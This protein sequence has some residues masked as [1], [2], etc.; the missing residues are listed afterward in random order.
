[1]A[2]SAMTRSSSTRMAR[3]LMTWA[4][5]AY[6]ATTRRFDSP[7][8]EGRSRG[9]LATAIFSWATVTARTSAMPASSNS[10]SDG[11]YIKE[12]AAMACTWPMPD[13]PHCLAMDSKGR[14]FLG[15]RGN[16]RMD[17]FT[18]D[19]QFTLPPGASSGRPSGCTIDSKDN[20]L[21]CVR[22][23]VPSRPS[24]RLGA[25]KMSGSAASADGLVTA[26]LH[27]GRQGCGSGEN[28]HLQWR[29]RLCRQERRDL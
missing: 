1:M 11:K 7:A 4:R 18:Q 3:S 24:P 26:L 23:R 9:C 5:P 8:A 25:R 2:R 17:I 10:V 28:G 12:W 6:R 15:D 21:V 22:F 16:T 20:L 29:R 14:L 27:P 13:I 19:G